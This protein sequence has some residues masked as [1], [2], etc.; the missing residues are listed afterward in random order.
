MISL[1]PINAS[2]A[3]TISTRLSVNRCGYFTAEPHLDPECGLPFDIIPD[4]PGVIAFL[5]KDGSASR[6]DACGGSMRQRMIDIYRGTERAES[7]VTSFFAF[8][9]HPQPEARSLELAKEN[10]RHYGNFPMRKAG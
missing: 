1:I 9:P 10:V 8:E 6:I 4:E 7:T 5:N 3:E 2:V